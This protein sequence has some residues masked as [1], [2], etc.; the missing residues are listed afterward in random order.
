MFCHEGGSP[1]DAAQVRY[2]F[3]KIAKAAG[4]GDGWVPRE[5]RHTF[6]SLMSNHGGVAIEKI[7]DLVGH[8]STA[9]IEIIYRHELRPVI[10]D[11]AQAMDKI[12]V[13]KS[14]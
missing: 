5:L 1:F 9:I 13:F 8:S 10:R 6:V 14:A 11:G 3:Q 4:L 7:S 2:G 12:I